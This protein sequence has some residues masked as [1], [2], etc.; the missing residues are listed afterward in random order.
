M[1]VAEGGQVMARVVESGMRV[2]GAVSASLASTA[3]MR[4]TSETALSVG[5]FYLRSTY[6]S[7]NLKEAYRMGSFGG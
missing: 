1:A 7:K 4:T 5:H 3:A 6:C 2:W